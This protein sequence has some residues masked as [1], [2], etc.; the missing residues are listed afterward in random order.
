VKIWP[1]EPPRTYIRLVDTD[2]ETK[3]RR[4]SDG[5]IPLACVD[6][7][8]IIK[9]LQQCPDM[10]LE[11]RVIQIFDKLELLAMDE[12][13]AIAFDRFFLRFAKGLTDIPTGENP[14]AQEFYEMVSQ[15]MEYILDTYASRCVG[16]KPDPPKDWRRK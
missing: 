6:W 4:I 3:Q 1:Q 7:D 11:S 5:Y 9:L 10:N 13:P 16:P 12:Q 2:R 8:D 14:L 15:F